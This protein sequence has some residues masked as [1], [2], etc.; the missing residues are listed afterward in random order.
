MTEMICAGAGLAAGIVLGRK[1][2]RRWKIANKRNQ[3]L[4]TIGTI[5][6]FLAGGY[7]MKL[8]GY[9]ILKIIRY[10][11]LMYA[12]LLLALLD[13]EKKVI[14]NRALLVLLGIRTVLMVGECICF[15]QLCMEI[16]M[17]AALGMAGGG[18]LFLLAG[19][20]AGRGIGMGD[21]KLIGIMGYF[22]GFQVLMSD[23]I[24]TLTLTVLAGLTALVLKKASLR[25][26]LPF[27]PFAAVGTMITILMGF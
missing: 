27:A 18:L 21:V 22:A 7:L 13:S 15:P 24:I 3:A 9:H 17:S 2:L 8:Y 16:V 12:L 23:L 26:E 6:V 19:L 10:W 14:P 5:I 4:L 1:Q 25:S 11:G 20:L